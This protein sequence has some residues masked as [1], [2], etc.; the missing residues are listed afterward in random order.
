MSVI[1]S[2][3]NKKMVLQVRRDG[4]VA[5]QTQQPACRPSIKTRPRD[6]PYA[7]VPSS[8]DPHLDESCDEGGRGIFYVADLEGGVGSFSL[9]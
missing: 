2:F 5:K 4:A 7:L 6:Y 3:S 8:R 9:Y 1:N